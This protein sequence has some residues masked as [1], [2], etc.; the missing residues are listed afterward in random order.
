MNSQLQHTGTAILC[1][2]GSH[3]VDFTLYQQGKIKIRKVSDIHPFNLT[4]GCFFVLHPQDEVTM[5]RS[6]YDR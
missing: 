6:L 5:V 3:D 1:I 4:H 2:G